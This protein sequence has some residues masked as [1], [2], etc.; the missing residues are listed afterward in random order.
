M[1]RQR[2]TVAA[3]DANRQFSE[4]L[5]DVRNGASVVITVHGK[6]V[7]RMVGIDD[8][9]AAADEARDTLLARLSSQRA[10]KA[11]RWTR[12]SLY[13]EES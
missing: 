11:A 5:R 10:T 1:N 12:E 8:R 7:A 2:R 13:A 3:A 4:L 9:A 6:A